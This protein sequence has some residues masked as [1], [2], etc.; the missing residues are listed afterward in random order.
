MAV[1][2]WQRNDAGRMADVLNG[3]GLSYPAGFQG[4]HARGQEFN[5]PPVV[6]GTVVSFGRL[7]VGRFEAYR[8]S[9]PEEFRFFAPPRKA[10]LIVE[11]YMSGAKVKEEV[12]NEVF[13]AALPALHSANNDTYDV[14]VKEFTGPSPDDIPAT[15]FEGYASVTGIVPY[16]AAAN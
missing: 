8:G 11:V 4:W 13:E 15:V 10:Q 3:V 2:N 7:S 14:D 12:W 9:Q 6:A 16:W 5:P 1:H